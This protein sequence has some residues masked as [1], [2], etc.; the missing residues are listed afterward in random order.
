MIDFALEAER[1]AGPRPEEA[2]YEACLLR[3]RPIMMTTMAALLGALPLA[4]GTGDGAE[5]R[6]PLGIAIVGG[7]IVSQ[8][9]TL[10]TTPV[11]YLYLDRLR[12]WRSAPAA[13]AARATGSA[14]GRHEAR[15]DAII[16]VA[17]G[18]SSAAVLAGAR[19]RGRPGLRAARRADAGG[20][21]GDRRLEVAQPRR[22]ALRG[23]LVGA[24]WRS[25]ARA[26]RGAGRRHEPDPRR[27]RG[28]LPPGPGAGAAGARA[29]V[30][31]R[32][33]RLSFARSR[34]SATLG[35]GRAS[36]SAAPRTTSRAARAC[37]SS[38]CGDGSAG[39]SSRARRR[40][41]ERRRPCERRARAAGA[42]RADYFQLR[43]HDAERRC[44]TRRSPATSAR[45]SSRETTTTRRRSR[46]ATWRRRRRSSR[47]R[48]PSFSTSREAG[49]ARARS[50]G[51]RRQT[52]GGLQL[53][54]AAARCE[55]RRSR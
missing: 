1:R 41:G 49:A 38:T 39:R 47:R 8:L 3:F 44:S 27:G 46:A 52:A 30:P 26:A 31:D 12:L 28:A 10:Y 40:A 13:R 19:L 32:R 33:R 23:R 29:T 18:S 15:A 6:R 45:S 24:L 35:G 50:R 21:Q 55:P 36:A 25:G 7:L 22:R 11:V 4:L 5:L 16:D 2:I 54:A 9:L 43:A 53:A 37:G 20:V 14:T 48:A 17:L 34:A 51:A 42:A